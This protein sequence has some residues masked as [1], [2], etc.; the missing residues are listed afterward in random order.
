MKNEC[1]GYKTL[2]PSRDHI[3]TYAQ[4]YKNVILVNII[5]K[6]AT[7]GW[8]CWPNDVDMLIDMA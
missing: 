2:N 4:I 1:T 5:T 6:K 7:M 8:K 3:T